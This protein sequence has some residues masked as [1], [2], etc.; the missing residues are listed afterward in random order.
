M[1]VAA[2]K[3]T[4]P[5]RKKIFKLL[6]IL[7]IIQLILGICSLVIGLYFY[8]TIARHLHKSNR[9]YS[10]I[11]VLYILSVGLMAVMLSIFGIKMSYNCSSKPFM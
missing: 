10:S 2:I 1:S 4:E 3:L 9:F 8:I 7:N 11:T 5:A 6:I